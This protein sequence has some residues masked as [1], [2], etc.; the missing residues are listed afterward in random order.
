MQLQHSACGDGERGAAVSP[1]AERQGAR[2]DAG[3]TGVGV[4]TTQGQGARSNFV[5]GQFAARCTVADHAAERCG[6]ATDRQGDCGA[7][8]C[9]AVD[10]AGA[11]DAGDRVTDIEL[12]SGALGDFDGG[13]VGQATAHGQHAGLDVGRA[14]IAV[15]TAQHQR[16]RT[17]LDQAAAGV[18]TADDAV[19]SGGYTTGHF[20]RSLAADTDAA[21]G[22]EGEG[23]VDLEFRPVFDHQAS[24]SGRR[25][26]RAQLQVAGDG[27]GTAPHHGV[28]GVGAVARQHQLAVAGLDEV[29]R[30]GVA[31]VEV[32]ALPI[33]HID[34][35]EQ[36]VQTRRAEH[37]AGSIADD[38]AVQT[39]LAQLHALR[40]IVAAVAVDQFASGQIRFGRDKAGA[41]CSATGGQRQG[42]VGQVGA[43]G[44]AFGQ[45]DRDRDRCA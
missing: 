11:L 42:G 35:R 40:E 43:G 7:C 10:V 25:H 38:G 36:R 4:Q 29:A 30:T 22:I 27:Q 33:G 16:A 26:V 14:G 34:L 1:F 23:G 37:V 17:S 19:V 18:G 39:D 21:F 24:R 13:G 44:D 28:A 31:A 9:A 45:V 20:D 6:V 15:R 8:Q 5:Q 32:D 41:A 2:V 12:V 3:G